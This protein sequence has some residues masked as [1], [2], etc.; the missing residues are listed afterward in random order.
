MYG[1]N[2][3]I[4]LYGTLYVMVL[5]YT[6]S[7]ITQSLYSVPLNRVWTVGIIACL[8]WKLMTPTYKD[9]LLC[10][11]G[12]IVCTCMTCFQAIDFL[13]NMNDLIYFLTAILWLLFMSNIENRKGLY[14]A[15]INHIMLTKI[16]IISSYVIIVGA[17]FTKT[18]YGYHWGKASYFVGFAGT[19]HAMASGMC[20]VASVL[21]LYS[22]TNKFSWINLFLFFIS[23]YVVFET[24]A[25]TFIIPILILVAFYIQNSYKN[26]GM[27]R[28]V[29]CIGIFVTIYMVVHSSMIEKFGFVVSGGNMAASQMDGFTSGRSLFWKVDLQEYARGNIFQMLF[30]K[31]FDHIY[32]IN[33]RYVNQ[34]IWAHNDFIHLLCGGGGNSRLNIYHNSFQFLQRTF[35]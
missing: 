6:I 29:Y 10:F 4:S 30:G 12:I 14:K 35:G 2:L 31:G 32:E 9:T 24:G 15:Y 18:T 13:R 7:T 33:A 19:Q 17:L 3:R 11:F 20:I 26:I 23:I 21:L 22:I 16:T 28:L 5:F 25:R 27:K 1:K 8:V 34:K